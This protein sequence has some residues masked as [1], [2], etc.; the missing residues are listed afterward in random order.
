MIQGITVVLINKTQTGTDAFN[1]PIYS[2]TRIPVDNVLVSPS[3]E[4][5]GDVVSE[6]DLEGRKSVYTLAIPKGDTHVWED[7]DVEFFGKRFHV[8]SS[9]TQGIDHLIPLSWNSKVMVELYE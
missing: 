4:A 6:L 9:Q 2:E 8:F 1:K 7:Q 5:S 3:L